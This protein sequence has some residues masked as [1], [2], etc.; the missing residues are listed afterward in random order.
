VK[1]KIHLILQDDTEDSVI[2]EANTLELCRSKA[3]GEIA[4][5]N[6]KDFWSE[7]IE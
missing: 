3:A 4:K 6:A 5:R 2:V 7:E 1:F